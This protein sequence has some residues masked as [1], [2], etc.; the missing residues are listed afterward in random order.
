MGR[1]LDVTVPLSPQVPTFPGD[2]CFQRHVTHSMAEGQPYNVSQ[3][4][5]GTHAGTHVDAPFHFIHEGARVHELPLHA[6]VGRA[7][8]VAMLEGAAVTVEQVRRWDLHGVERL[9]VRTRNSGTLRQPGFRED[10][11]YVEPDAAGLLAAQGLALL[12]W[13]YLSIEKF[14]SHDFAAHRALLGAGVVIVEGL[15]LS[16]VEP[17]DY[18]L[19]CLPLLIVGADGAPAR[20][21]LETLS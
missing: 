21:V 2:P 15:D 13:D 1:L 14:G 16:A 17:G 19:A 18:H 6:L 12:G 5:L 8:V 10:F 11:V 7:R 3:L 20:V 9:L 4:V